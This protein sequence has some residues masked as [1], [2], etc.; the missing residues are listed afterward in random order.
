MAGTSPRARARRAPSRYRLTPGDLVRTPA[1][2]GVITDFRD[3]TVYDP[4]MA[5][6][7][8]DGRERWYQYRDVSRTLETPE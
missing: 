7:L 4:A 3:N 1:G 8:I 2:V 6:V 5:Q